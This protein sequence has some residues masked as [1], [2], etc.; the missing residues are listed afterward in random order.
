MNAARGFLCHPLLADFEHGFGTRGALEPPCYRPHQVHGRRVEVLRGAPTGAS[1]TADAVIAT[2]AGARIA[3]VTAD[4]VPI[5]L[6]HPLGVVAAVHAG[7]RGLAGG[8]IAATLEKLADLDVAPEQASAV[9]G[10]HICATHYEIDEPVRAALAPRFG[11]SLGAALRN[12]R[13]GHW[14]LELAALA[15]AELR[16]GGLGADRIATLADS[17][18]FAGTRF[19]SRRRDGGGDAR[20]LHFITARA[21]IDSG[22]RSA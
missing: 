17:C 22:E 2:Y 7:W 20:L 11:T 5:L 14:L 3:V 6:A 10:P 21:A 1:D 9:I 15:A 4:C 13:P 12:S 8:V 16:A 19:E 18:T